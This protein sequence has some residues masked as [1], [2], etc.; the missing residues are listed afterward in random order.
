MRVSSL[1]L[2]LA[3]TGCYDNSAA[4]NRARERQAYIDLAVSR[5]VSSE[6]AAGH[7]EETNRKPTIEDK[8]RERVRE[9]Q[10]Y[11]QM[12]QADPGSIYC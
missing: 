11:K 8:H 4:E 12:C 7:W 2:A 6:A 9:E 3:L 1:I 5:G 10:E